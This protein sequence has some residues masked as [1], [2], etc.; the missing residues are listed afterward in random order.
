M[1]YDK[2]NQVMKSFAC[3][4]KLANSFNQ[5]CKQNS[6]SPSSVLR[7][8]MMAYVLDSSV[9]DMLSEKETVSDFLISFDIKDF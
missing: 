1:A 3:S 7:R 6:Y 4:K 9:N 2:K 5:A 8:L